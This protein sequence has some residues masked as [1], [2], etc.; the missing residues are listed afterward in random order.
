[1]ISASIDLALKRLCNVSYTCVFNLN[2]VYCGVNQAIPLKESY[3]GKIILFF[4]ITSILISNPMCYGQ[5]IEVSDPR[6]ELRGNDVHIFYDILN[7]DPSDEFTVSMQ[8]TDS[9]GKE[10][11]VNSLT[12]DIGELVKGGSNKH[13]VWDLTADKVVM[14]AQIYV[15][16]YAKAILL[17]EEEPVEESQQELTDVSDP[18]KDEDSPAVD[19]Q[20]TEA[21]PIKEAPIEETSDT[22][23]SPG[24]GTKSYNRTSIILQSI[25]LP[26]LGLSRM[27]GKP[28]WL[29]GVA[30]YGCLAGSI[31]LNRAAIDTYE[32][33]PQHIDW[34]NKNDLFQQS[35]K[36][37]GISELL[38]YAALG[39][40]VSD[41]IWTII[42]TSDL[43]KSSL[44]SETNG[45]SIRTTIDPLSYAPLIGMRYVF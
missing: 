3:M 14:N 2:V 32:Q 10:V 38:A 29:K 7:S 16:I 22:K 8:I 17:L 24:A 25:P 19:T 13:I 9:T 39:I 26:G 44:Y 27:T 35:Q 6:L 28:H 45:L 12:G 31:I 15:K 5:T 42:G 34:D 40:W 1:M 36:Q 4:L 41:V 37:D 20:K 11:A 21:E 23:S 30:A 18:D 43:K 33:I